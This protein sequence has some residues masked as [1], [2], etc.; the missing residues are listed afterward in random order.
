MRRHSRE[1]LA[2]ISSAQNRFIKKASRFRL[3]FSLMHAMSFPALTLH[4]L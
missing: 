1:H 2:P 4:P 3:A